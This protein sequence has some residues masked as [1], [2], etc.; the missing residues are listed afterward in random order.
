MACS[1]V[2]PAVSLH[3]Y[4][5]FP[6]PK[7][8]LRT[9]PWLLALIYGIPLV[10]LAA[11][12]GIYL[13]L[14]AIRDEA[15][16]TTAL[17]WTIFGNGILAYLAVAVTFYVA[18]VAALFYS[19]RAASDATERNQV[20]WIF[21]GSL[22]ALIP[23]SYT[24]YLIFWEPDDFGA[25]AGEWPMFVASFCFTVAFA[26]SI[27]RY[28]LMQLDQL[29]SSGMLYFLIS[30]AA[31][32]LYYVVVL[33]LMLVSG[34]IPA[35]SFPHAVAFSAAALVFLLVL[36]L[37]RGGVKRALDRRFNRQKLQLDRT[38]HRLGAAI[39]QLVDPPTLA[40]RLLQT[41]GEVLTV[42][43][44]A[45][46]LREGEPPIY[47]LAGCLGSTPPPLA[48]LSSGCPLVE[49]L[50]TRPAL[51]ARPG[52]ATDPTQRQLRLL[53]GTVA[54]AIEHEDRLL[55][56]L[57]LGPK[58]S[59]P[60]ES[61]DLELLAAFAQ[62]TALALENADGHRTI[63]GLNKD[64]QA[65]V[66]KIAEQQH[67]I[68]ALQAQLTN[69]AV[70]SPATKSQDSADEIP[71]I[72]ANGEVE[73]GA[74]E[75][76]VDGSGIIGSSHS[77]RHVLALARK[78]ANSP[79]AVLIRGESG[80]GKELVARVLHE[81]SPRAGKPYV[82]VHCAALAPTLLESELFGHVKG[83][84]TG[85][86][87]DKIGRFEMANGGTIFLDEVGDIPLDVQTKLLRV[88]Q[89][90][91]IERVGSSE[92]LAVDVRV[93]AATH[94]DLDELMRQKRFREDLYFRINVIPIAV[95]PLRSRR[96]DIPELALYFLNLYARRCGKAVQQFDD[97]AMATIKAYDWPGNVREL[98]NVVERT[99]VITDGQIVTVDD[100]PP[101]IQEP[102]IEP[103]ASVTEWY[104][105]GPTSLGVRA[106]RSERGRYERERLVRALAAADGNK[107][108]AARA[109]GLARSTLL[110]RLKKYGLS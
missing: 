64:L 104:G 85:A 27:T 4:L 109:L 76:V 14:R 39:E 73:N 91:T 66:E 46:Y 52:L 84:F 54:H 45:V 8:L 16:E 48:E 96:E 51:V 100:L 71:T 110:S 63:D 30:F 99:V 58:H 75:A 94:Q 18:S 95:P 106:E 11:L 86:H 17:P 105:S 37:A 29:V 10:S 55:A 67:R 5:E 42:T 32:A 50:R 35:P 25:G 69:R 88:L 40:R 80:T 36:D 87:R 24:L 15:A 60:Y 90:K 9:R 59:G 28:R 31:G 83:A 97:D 43:S 49:A 77:I 103:T 44:G 3:F 61:S 20:K 107:A 6:R 34:V 108:E 102:L 2:M 78:A 101:E 53:G 23:I 41:T 13:Y 47:R 62:L 12:T 38:L 57:V 19:F 56:F 81:Q 70:R 79:S 89:E 7:P 68:L 98:E 74:V 92:P 33:F 22:L 82:K 72:P 1:I 65:K 21:V 93:I 26:I